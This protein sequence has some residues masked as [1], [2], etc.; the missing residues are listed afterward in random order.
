MKLVVATSS[1]RDGLQFKEVTELVL[2]T[3]Q[4]DEQNKDTHPNCK[5]QQQQQEV[6]SL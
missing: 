4:M 1:K 2:A 6:C 3:S 5:Q